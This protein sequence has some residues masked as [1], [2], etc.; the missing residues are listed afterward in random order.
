MQQAFLG[1]RV[2]LPHPAIP[3]E[4][5]VAYVWELLRIRRFRSA[6]DIMERLGSLQ[7]LE[8]VRAF[9]W[10]RLERWDALDTDAAR[11]DAQPVVT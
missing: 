3:E 6:L 2:D 11:P 8:T 9:C 10:A 1:R 4:N 5:S 7:E